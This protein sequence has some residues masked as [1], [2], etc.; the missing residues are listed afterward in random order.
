MKKEKGKKGK[1]YKKIKRVKKTDM[2]KIYM[3]I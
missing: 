1:I 3:N 2:G